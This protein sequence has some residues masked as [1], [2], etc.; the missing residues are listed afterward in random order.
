MSPAVQTFR[1]SVASG[2]CL[3]LGMTLIPLFSWGGLHYTLATCL[4][5]LIVC[6]V[7]FFL[8]CFWTFSVETSLKS[9]VR[10][11]S[12][13]AL[14]LPLTIVLIAIGHDFVGL[15]VVVSAAAASLVLIAW[16]FLAVRWAVSRQPRKASS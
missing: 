2:I 14:N 12:A 5:F 6:A 8:H 13:M 1:Y 15:S 16:N 9:F 3:V 4:A 11:A 7:G 10:Y